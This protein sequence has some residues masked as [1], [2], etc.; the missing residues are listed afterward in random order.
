[1]VHNDVPRSPALPPALDMRRGAC[2]TLD[3]PMMTGDGLLTRL[4]LRAGR[5]SPTDLAYLAR[6]A[7][8]HGNGLVEITARG[9]LQIRGL[10]DASSASFSAAVLSRLDIETGLVVD[11]SPLGGDDPSEKADPRPLAATIHA[12]SEPLWPRLAPKLS[13]VVDAGGQISLAGLKADI[14]LTAVDAHHWAVAI[15]QQLPR[16]LAPDAAIALTLNTLTEL[17][18]LGSQARATDLPIFDSASGSTS[19]SASVAAPDDHVHVRSS[20][21]AFRLNCGSTFGVALPFG[22]SDS[23]SLIAFADAAAAT[24]VTQ[25]R[26]AP[27]R[28]L[29]ADEA[30]PALLEIARRLAFITEPTDPRLRVSA[31]AGSEGCRSGEIAARRF[32]ADYASLVSRDH[33]LHISGCAKGCAHPGPADLTLVGRSDGIGLVIHGRAGDTPREIVQNDGIALALRRAQEGR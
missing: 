17:A 19:P 12:G 31:C 29:L 14:R 23:E 15:G 8:M 11:V 28:A 16:V 25:F 5:I 30:S 33:H 9:N 26:L 10:T 27:G 7:K 3:K 4:R 18:T 6:L 24:G 22:S 32:A 13:V 21:G 1:M 2:P 20:I